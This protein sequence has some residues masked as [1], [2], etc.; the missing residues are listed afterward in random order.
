[1]SYFGLISQNQGDYD[2]RKWI[3]RSILNHTKQ[4]VHHQN[5]MVVYAKM[6]YYGGIIANTNNR[7]RITE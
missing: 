6:L 2:K 7:F 5:I 1:M 4:W 3:G